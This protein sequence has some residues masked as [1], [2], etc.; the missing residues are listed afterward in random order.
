MRAILRGQNV[1]MRVV[2]LVCCSVW[3]NMGIPLERHPPTKLNENDN[4][5]TYQT[6]IKI[7]DIG[8][9]SAYWDTDR[10]S[11]CETICYVIACYIMLYYI[12]RSICLHAAL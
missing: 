12:I 4:V 5:L 7:R 3:F 2:H 11:M 6:A 8:V 1:S 9:D 10:N